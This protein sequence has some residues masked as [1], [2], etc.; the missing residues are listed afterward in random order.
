MEGLYS[1]PHTGRVYL[2]ARSR[3]M[4]PAESLWTLD[5]QMG[6]WKESQLL[7]GAMFHPVMF[8]LTEGPLRVFWDEVDW[9]RPTSA[10]AE[11]VGGKTHLVTP[12]DTWVNFRVPYSA[13]QDA[14]SNVH[15]AAY[16]RLD[17]HRDTLVHIYEQG[18]HWNQEVVQDFGSSPELA[19]TGPC[20]L[21]ASDGLLHV[22]YFEPARGEIRHGVRIGQQ[23]RIAAVVRSRRLWLYVVSETRHLGPP[24]V[25]R[26]LPAGALVLA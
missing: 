17:A 1:D 18:G 15:F 14:G 20:A 10:I 16:A 24:E 12:S 25:V 21:F 22:F 5:G 9:E 23:W 7:T 26:F 4:E 13:T 19:S 6:S 11:L 3:G 2:L 8:T